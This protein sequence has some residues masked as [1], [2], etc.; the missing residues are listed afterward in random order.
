MDGA[1]GVPRERPRLNLKPRD[2]AAAAKAEAER[3][4]Q[5]RKPSYVI[6]RSVL[7]A[8]PSEEEA[9]GLARPPRGLRRRWPPRVST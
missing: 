5:V 7:D 1:A 2:P 3:Q 6:R 8:R 9:R 4:A